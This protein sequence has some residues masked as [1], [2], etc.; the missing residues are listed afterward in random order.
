MTEPIGIQQALLRERAHHMRAISELRAKQ[1]Q[2]RAW[3]RLSEVHADAIQQHQEA[4]AI[5]DAERRAP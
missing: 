5:I 1:R 2:A 3:E 4:I